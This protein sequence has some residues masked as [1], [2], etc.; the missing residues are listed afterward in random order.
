M[1]T[2][3]SY[4]SQNSKKWIYYRI[5]HLRGKLSYSSQNVANPIFFQLEK[6]LSLI[7]LDV[8]STSGLI[9][10]VGDQILYKAPE[11]FP[12]IIITVKDKRLYDLT[13]FFDPKIEQ[14][15]ELFDQV[16]IHFFHSYAKN[17]SVHFFLELDDFMLFNAQW[18]IYELR[19]NS[20]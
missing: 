20:K 10:I 13:K 9:F 11:I 17:F 7:S 14:V 8:F 12:K 18:N 19:A 15:S 5:L 1:D 3:T 4:R 16:F 2:E 6:Q